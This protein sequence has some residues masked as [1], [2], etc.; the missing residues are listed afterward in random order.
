LADN[1]RLLEGHQ[2]IVK[3]T[4]GQSQVPDRERQVGGSDLAQPMTF[5]L[6]GRMFGQST[7]FGV[8]GPNRPDQ[9]DRPDQ[10]SRGQIVGTRALRHRERLGERILGLGKPAEIAVQLGLDH[11]GT[12]NRRSVVELARTRE[13]TFDQG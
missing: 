10:S 3:T 13:R 5:D 7:R 2:C 4:L 1:E 8:A 12:R 11:K 9:L 6:G